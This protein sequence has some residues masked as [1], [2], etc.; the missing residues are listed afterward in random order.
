M[1]NRWAKFYNDSTARVDDADIILSEVIKRFEVL[2]HPS[3][4]YNVLVDMRRQG[5]KALTCRFTQNQLS[6][7]N[8]RLTLH[9]CFCAGAV[10][11]RLLK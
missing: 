4:A 3:I 11:G 6:A 5:L 8:F 10:I 9:T 7:I 1:L 2:A